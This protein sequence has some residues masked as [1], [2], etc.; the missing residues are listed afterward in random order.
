MKKESMAVGT[1][2]FNEPTSTGYMFPSFDVI[3]ALEYGADPAF[4]MGNDVVEAVMGREEARMAK[5]LE[6]PDPDYDPEAHR[7]RSWDDYLDERFGDERLVFR[8]SVYLYSEVG[9]A[10]KRSEIAEIADRI[11]TGLTKA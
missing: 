1:I 5:L 10:D 4:F 7:G 9:A 3:E 6:N 8:L 2:R 11:K